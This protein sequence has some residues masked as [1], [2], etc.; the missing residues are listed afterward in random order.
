[1]S[2]ALQIGN[3]PLLLRSRTGLLRTAGLQS[4]VLVGLAEALDRIPSAT[5]DVA[6]LCHT[7]SSAD[8]AAVIA[9]L[10]RRNPHAPILLIGRRSYTPDA[11][12]DGV[13][14][15]L[16]ASP[17]KIIAALRDLLMRTPRSQERQEA[18]E[19]TARR[20]HLPIAAAQS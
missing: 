12:A 19:Q 14:L 8:R 20:P 13:D 1:M 18:Q 4:L 7:L 5:W 6:I 10:R 16:S 11:E 2:Q 15:V 17:A 9:A 3:D